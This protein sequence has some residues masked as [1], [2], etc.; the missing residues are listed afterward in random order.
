MAEWAT[1]ERIQTHQASQ[2]DLREWLRLVAEGLLE[3]NRRL[4]QIERETGYGKL[5]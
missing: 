2:I 1:L 3:V 5:Q 4:Q